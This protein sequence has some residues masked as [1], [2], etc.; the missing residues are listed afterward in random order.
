MARNASSKDAGGVSESRFCMWR[1]VVAMMHADEVVKP[2]EVNFILEHIRDEPL[3]DEQ[4]AVLQ[5]DIKTP[6]TIDVLAAGITHP[7]DRHDFFHLARAMA[8]ADGELDRS[9]RA[10][11]M[12][13]GELRRGEEEANV[14]RVPLQ[15]LEEYS[16]ERRSRA[17]ESGKLW[18]RLKALFS[19]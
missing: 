16:R 14:K 13:F 5:E 9:E 12:R 4:R 19:R 10:V 17:G 6:A 7:V 11:L 2:H 18:S 3:S 8:W 15:S 1:A